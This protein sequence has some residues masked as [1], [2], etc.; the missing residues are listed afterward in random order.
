MARAKSIRNEQHRQIAHDLSNALADQTRAFEACQLTLNRYLAATEIL[1][2]LEAQEENEIPVDVERMLE[3]Q[4]RV[5]DAE[6]D[7]FRSRAEYA[8]TIKNVHFTKGT[9]LSWFDFGVQDDTATESALGSETIVIPP[10]PSAVPALPDFTQ[11]L[12]MHDEIQ[13]DSDTLELDAPE[14]LP[15]EQPRLVPPET[16][17][18]AGVIRLS[19]H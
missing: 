19:D 9:L 4:R 7:H 17:A 14:T 10:P 1:N 13:N 11:P 6:L 5:V 15:M 12:P 3:A 8:V 2:V 16:A 18:K